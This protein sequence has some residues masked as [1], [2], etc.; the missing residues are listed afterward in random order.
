MKKFRSHL[1]PLKTLSAALATCFAVNAQA[2]P[3]APTVSAGNA[4][5]QQSGNSLTVTN[6][7]GTIINWNS[8]SIG[9]GESTHFIQPT[10]SSSVLNRVVGIDPSQIYGT[11]SSNGRIYLV[12]PNGI[13]VGPGGRVDAAAF[14]ASTLDITDQ[15]FLAGRMVF[16]RGDKAGR[17][18]ND[19]VIITPEG[20]RVY[21]IGSQ[22]D[23]NGAIVAPNGEVV[24]AAGQSVQVLD[25]GTPG[26][27]VEFSASDESV[28]NFGSIAA[29]GGRIGLA[30]ALV[31]NSGTLNASSVAREG[32]RIFL[33]ASKQVEVDAAGRIVANGT[34]GG[35]VELQSDDTTMVSGQIE[36]K[37]SVATGGRVEVLG[38][39]VGVFDGASIDASGQTGGGTILV[40]GDL[41]GR[42][43]AVQNAFIT[44]FGR[45]ARLD[46]N[47]G[48][49]GDGGKII[50]WA[51]DTTRAYGQISARGGA[52]GGDG[53]FA[54]VSG[55]RYLDFQASAN[56]RAPNGEN[57]SLLLDPSS[58]LVFT[59]TG[60]ADYGGG[61]APDGTQ[62]TL[63]GGDTPATLFWDSTIAP[64]FTFGNVILTTSAAYGDGS[65]TFTPGFYSSPTSNTLRLLASSNGVSPSG[66]IT[67]DGAQIE[68]PNGSVELYAGWSGAS[69]VTPQLSGAYGDISLAGGSVGQGRFRAASA[70]LFAA[71]NITLGAG[72][73]GGAYGGAVETSGDLL[74]QA[75]NLFI[76]AAT[77]SFGYG[78]SFVSS[79]GNQTFNLGLDGNL[80]HVGGG[81]FLAG[82]SGSTVTNGVAAIEQNGL[83]GSQTF[84]L[85]GGATVSL[86]G[87]SG[88][89]TG[90][91]CFPG[92]TS[93]A[94]SNNEARIGAGGAGGQFFYFHDAGGSINLTAGSSVLGVGRNSAEI[95][96]KGTGQQVIQGMSLG[97]ADL[98]KGPAISITGGA[99]GGAASVFYGGQF[100]SIANEALISAEGTQ[101][102]KARQINMNGG[103]S[104]GGFYG[105]AFI[106]APNQDIAVYGGNLVMDG[107]YGGGFTYQVDAGAFVP[108]GAALIGWDTDAT[109][110]ISLDDAGGS[111]GNLEMN[112]NFANGGDAAIGSLSGKANVTVNALG[113]I[114]LSNTGGGQARIGSATG[115]S[116]SSILIHS[117][118][119]NCLTLCGPT[120]G[121]LLDGELRVG[122]SDT[123]QLTSNVSNINQTATIG[124]IYGGSLLANAYGSVFMDGAN[125]V[126]TVDLTSSTGG[127]SY[128]T[129]APT[130]TFSAAAFSTI[131]LVANPLAQALPGP[132]NLALGLLSA[133]GAVSI[134]ADGAILDNNGTATNI[135]TSGAVF[136]S[137]SSGGSSI[138]TLAVS[139]DIDGA[140]SITV[141]VTSTASYGGIRINQTNPP[142]GLKTVALSDASLFGGQFVNYSTTSNI[143]AANFGMV[144]L[145]GGNSP[146]SLLSAGSIDT[147]TAL[148]NGFVVSSGTGD[149][150]L[151]A[152]GNMILANATIGSGNNIT[153]SAGGLL[154]V[155][156]SLIASKVATLS[157]S[158]VNLGL[159]A[160]LSGASGAAIST[161]G[162][163]TIAGAVASSA[164][165]VAISANTI[166]MQTGSTVAGATGVAITSVGDVTLNGSSIDAS[167]GT[168]GSLTLNSGGAVA[169]TG[170]QFIA[171][172]GGL[173]L[174]GT[175]LLLNSSTL[176]SSAS[177]LVSGVNLGTTGT[178][179]ISGNNGVLLKGSSGVS[180]SG[181]VINSTAGTVAADSLAGSVVF[182]G[183]AVSGANASFTAAST[184]GISGSNVNTIG[185]IDLKGG[186]INLTGSS[187][188]SS[189]AAVSAISG[190]TMTLD[191]ASVSGASGIAATTTGSLLLDN[192]SSISAGNGS[193][194]GQITLTSGGDIVLN[195]ASS[196]S[197]AVPLAPVANIALAAAGNLKLNNGSRVQASDDV[198]ISLTGAASSLILNETSGL[199]ASSIVSDMVTGVAATTYLSF[200]NLAERGI[201]IDGVATTTSVANGSGFFTIDPSTP[202][203]LGAGLQIVY[204]IASGVDPVATELGTIFDTSTRDTENI[205]NIET[206]EVQALAAEIAEEEETGEQQDGN[207]NPSEGNEDGSG[208]SKPAQCT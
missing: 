69:T 149:V 41:Q 81:V 167:A 10:A 59:G 46:A 185:I 86:S 60:T 12:N 53:G 150:S 101:M 120:T 51:D 77:N 138:G 48:T 72:P 112:S 142:V 181:G 5:F 31:R 83:A 49:R 39:K 4:S 192:A 165:T 37:G 70:K 66:N 187:I 42:N 201:I 110:N 163:L 2:L 125:R 55:H 45:N 182:S 33:R 35:T 139:A 19:G 134:S 194:N 18:V 102:I 84:N 145:L 16:T 152:G 13:F 78:G 196:I 111:T 26:V 118:Q 76:S 117:D 186:A 34:R 130:T 188:A 90:T 85:Y 94:C 207:A 174:S 177:V 64:Q 158:S 193:L 143:D 190:S 173:T 25:T 175:N 87:G 82:A 198:S 156:S 103:G 191:A 22:V 172:S 159:G 63:S 180:L 132:G 61:N 28:Q 106:V 11:L 27:T 40:G 21:L 29:G 3:T 136:M 98:A 50:V 89:L 131:N 24:L 109:I 189:A 14:V 8:F 79:T 122:A 65:I 113:A 30:G 80:N 20:G 183:T 135:A 137:S 105:G 75:Q 43:E 114:R 17:V 107:G 91:G 141:D 179:L 7:N 58:I 147:S 129:V 200:T 38:N 93:L 203:V 140:S 169:A 155:S 170:A 96:Y 71:R 197:N 168:T 52:E 54:E 88:S 195:N 133:G 128:R 68:M 92:D 178:T 115:V 97:V 104:L 99:G 144:A 127:I 154:D 23:N 171:G 56:L 153:A 32:G 9:A 67:L 123:I 151:V 124:S 47:A 162:A 119:D 148:A 126:P 205:N 108:S 1:P 73:Y 157:G 116:G 160:T 176:N 57:G 62:W 15:D 199:A 121:M 95:G 208:K 161:S 146:V 184:L 206:Q 166:Q 100:Q 202:A 44:W 74:V 164:G 204:G 36:A 6:S